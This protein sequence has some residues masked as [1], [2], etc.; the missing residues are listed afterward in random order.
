MANSII[1]APAPL[2][3]DPLGAG[4]GGSKMTNTEARAIVAELI[5]WAG[6]F[7]HPKAQT[8]LGALTDVERL[9][10]HAWTEIDEAL[11][12]LSLMGSDPPR[13]EEHLQVAMSYLHR[14]Q[15]RG[16][17][18]GNAEFVLP[19]GRRRAPAREQARV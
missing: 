10:V 16:G 19:Y 5:G 11:T 15:D 8:L 3:H 7:Q 2:H 1:G 18:V 6:Q 13:A 14:W 9:F 17:R 12:R 4:W